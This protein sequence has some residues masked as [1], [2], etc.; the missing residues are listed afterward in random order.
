M[1]SRAYIKIDVWRASRVQ[2]VRT[3][4]KAI[5][6]NPE[7]LRVR[8]LQAPSDMA[9]AVGKFVVGLRTDGHGSMIRDGDDH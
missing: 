6:D 2:T 7:V 8:E 1:V 9:R 4:A 3:E 5:R